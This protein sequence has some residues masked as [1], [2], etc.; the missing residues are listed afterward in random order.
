MA[1]TYLERHNVYISIIFCEFE[2]QKNINF[3]RCCH[4]FLFFIDDLISPLSLSLSALSVLI[5]LFLY[6]ANFISLIL[7]FFI[8]LCS[9]S[10]M[11][12][13]IFGGLVILFISYLY[14]GLWCQTLSN[15]LEISKSRAPVLYPPCFSLNI[16][17]TI[18]ASLIIVPCPCYSS[19]MISNNVYF[20]NIHKH[21]NFWCLLVLRKYV[22]KCLNL[23]I[24]SKKKFCKGDKSIFLQFNKIS[25]SRFRV[26][27]IQHNLDW[28]NSRKISSNNQ[29]DMKS[30]PLLNI[31]K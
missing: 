8:L 29:V 6:L 21:L 19:G 30:S 4:F 15:A 16:I 1:D 26:Q 14:I 27:I 23:L 18:L 31:F 24:N 2:D 10:T 22:D 7:G 25:E 17:S 11:K 5:G 3:S 9:S 13:R 28:Y 20:M 12:S